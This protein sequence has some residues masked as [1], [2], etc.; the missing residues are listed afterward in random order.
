M[1]DKL[2]EVSQPMALT[3]P[4]ALLELMRGGQLSADAVRAVA[5]IYERQLERDSISA[6]NAA[7]V[8]FQERCP[9]IDKVQNIEFTTK[10]GGK[11]KSAYAPLNHI[12]SIIGPHA[13]AEGFSWTFEPYYPENKVGVV[14][15]LRHAQ[16]H[17]I[18]VPFEVP[19]DADA[20]LSG[21]HTSASAASFAERYALCL[22][23]GI[24]T[25]KRDDDGKAFTNSALITS[26]QAADL[27]MKCEAAGRGEAELCKRYG[28]SKFEELPSVNLPGIVG[29]LDQIIRE[30]KRD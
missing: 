25:W 13:R 23:L 6:F 7:M 27:A 12:V 11:F 21:A 3:G 2:A 20:Y 26:E 15:V 19:V 24:T 4:N 18:R 28:V 8:R 16:G 17:S 1:T 5:E 29:V 10:K 22:A 14:C 30:R 9:R